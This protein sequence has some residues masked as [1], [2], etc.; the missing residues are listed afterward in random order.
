MAVIDRRCDRP[1]PRQR[2]RGE[3]GE[4]LRGRDLEFRPGPGAS[5]WTRTRF[6]ALR[7]PSE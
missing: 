4:V 1:I 5:K 2:M 7:E 6:A 3:D